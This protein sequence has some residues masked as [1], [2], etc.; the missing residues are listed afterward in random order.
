MEEVSQVFNKL[1][2]RH[3]DFGNVRYWEEPERCGWLMKQGMLFHT[4]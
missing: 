3:D 2:G 1:L 4:L